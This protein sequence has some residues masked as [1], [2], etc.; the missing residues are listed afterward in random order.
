MCKSFMNGGVYM[1]KIYTYSLDYSVEASSDKEASDKIKTLIL[2]DARAYFSSKEAL[3]G[4]LDD[5]DGLICF[6]H[7]SG[8]S[9]LRIDK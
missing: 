6:S 8:K 9:S 7:I 3:D 2:E 4:F 1:S 5:N